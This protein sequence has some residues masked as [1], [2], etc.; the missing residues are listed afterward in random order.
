MPAFFRVFI[1]VFA[2][3][4]MKPSNVKKPGKLVAIVSMTVEFDPLETYSMIGTRYSVFN[5][6]E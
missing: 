6:S 4:T 2:F 3:T 1:S 5:S